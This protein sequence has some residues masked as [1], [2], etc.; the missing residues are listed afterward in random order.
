MTNYVEKENTRQNLLNDIVLAKYSYAKC[1]EF[2]RSCKAKNSNNEASDLID[3]SVSTALYDSCVKGFDY[4]IVGCVLNMA[5]GRRTFIT[6]LAT[7]G[8]SVRVIAE[9]VGHSSIATTKRYIDVN[10]VLISDAVEL[11]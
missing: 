8:A 9:A 6:K 11:V 5:D 4:Y 7:S 3:K 10:D 1:E 2:I